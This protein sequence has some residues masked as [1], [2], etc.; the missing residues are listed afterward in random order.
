MGNDGGSIPRRIE[1]VKEKA[2]EVII[3]PDLE[4]IA[5]WFYC[6]L[7]KRLLEQP[8]V[9]CGLGKLYNQD[10]IIEYLL[11][12]NTY[13]DGDKICSHITSLKD[14]TKL[15]LT[16]NPAFNN[17]KGATTMGN[18]E[19]DIKKMNGKHRFVYLDTCGCVFAEQALK[20]IPT[21]ECVSCGKPFENQN[22][23]IINPNKE[24]QER[25]KG[26]ME[27]KKAKAKAERKA[28]KA[29]NGDKKR[30]KKDSPDITTET[31]KKKLATANIQSSA[32]V[33]VLDK[34]A[35][36]LAEKQ[37]NS[38]NLSKAVKSI[39]GSKDKKDN[40]NY[41]TKGTFTRY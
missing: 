14:T 26:L 28:K 16:P 17:D 7:S 37:K 1:L 19:K 36:E 20:E 12:P 15:N 25:M 5:A 39:Y 23:I 13:G 21:K 18:L 40:G 24:E 29:K 9:S 27:E 4:R 33:A 31:P 10:A 30:K 2:K 22:I 38:P 3:N 32:A 6:A 34:V 41:L 35:Q 11:D 8:V